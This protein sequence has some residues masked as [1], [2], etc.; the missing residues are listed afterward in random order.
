M[1]SQTQEPGTDRPAFKP[2]DSE[3]R[4]II[5]EELD[6]TI[7][8]EASAGTGKTTSL[9]QRIVNLVVSGKTTMDRIAAITF[10]ELAA[11]ELR[12]PG[13]AGTGKGG[14]QCHPTGSGTGVVP[15]GSF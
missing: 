3:E 8:V 6:D 15:A 5:T 7:F 4:R 14:S 10:T 1:T 12:D 13:A 2:A 11:A 9:V